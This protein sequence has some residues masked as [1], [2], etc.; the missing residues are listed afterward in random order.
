MRYKPPAKIEKL[1]HN[2]L[3]QTASPNERVSMMWASNVNTLGHRLR[4]LNLKIIKN[5]LK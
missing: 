2:P 1:A 5:K 4:M 3:L